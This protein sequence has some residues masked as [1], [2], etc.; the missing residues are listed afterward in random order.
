MTTRHSIHIEAPVEKVFAFV[1]DPVNFHELA[2]RHTPPLEIKDVKQTVDGV[3]SYYVWVA[4][5]RGFRMEGFCV[6]TEFIPDRRIT[7]RSSLAADGDWTYLFEPEGSGTRLTTESHARS[8][9]RIPPFRQLAERLH[10][11]NAEQLL[12]ELKARMEA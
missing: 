11:R 7:E 6:Y 1:K 2:Q 4:R 8:F 12:P 5:S 10:G 9:W 3:G